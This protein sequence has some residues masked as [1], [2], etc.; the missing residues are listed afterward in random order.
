MLI[1]I[2]LFMTCLVLAH[3]QLLI[4][5]KNKECCLNIHIGLRDNQELLQCCMISFIFYKKPLLQDWEKRLYHV[6]YRKQ[7]YAFFFHKE[8]EEMGENISKQIRCSVL[9]GLLEICLR[10][11]GK[12][13]ED[14]K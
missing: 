9:R 6:M 7:I 1:E 12:R 5:T 10:N 13:Q 8:S 2:L 3:T 11:L 14:G 4:A